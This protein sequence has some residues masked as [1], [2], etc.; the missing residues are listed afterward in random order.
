MEPEV[1]YRLIKK[2]IQTEDEG[3]LM[4]IEAILTKGAELTDEHKT[5]LDER[6]IAHSL[7]RFA[8]NSWNDV[9][10]QIKKRL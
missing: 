5:V 4:Q 1:K 10:S 7:D 6:L 9:K 2:R 8:G 3:L